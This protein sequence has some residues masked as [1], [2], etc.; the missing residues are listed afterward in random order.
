MAK[1]GEGIHEGERLVVP[2]LAPGKASLSGDGADAVKMRMLDRRPPA[3]ELLAVGAKEGVEQSFELKLSYK[4]GGSE[5]LS[6]FVVP[7][8]APSNR[9]AF[10][11]HPEPLQF[12]RR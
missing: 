8:G 4:D 10:L 12:L 9:R 3:V 6:Y 7:K 2:L 11:P 5:T 1:F